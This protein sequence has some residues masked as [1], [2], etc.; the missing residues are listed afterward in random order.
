VALE[1]L[2]SL[3]KDLIGMY[4]KTNESLLMLVIGYLLLLLPLSIL[5][6]FMEKRLR[7]AGFGN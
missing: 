7:Y 6:R 2:M 5:F 3:A 1:D 4:Y